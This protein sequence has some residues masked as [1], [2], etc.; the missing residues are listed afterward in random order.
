MKTKKFFSDFFWTIHFMFSPIIVFLFGYCPKKP[1]EIWGMYK[2]ALKNQ[3]FS[4]DIKFDNPRRD[5]LFWYWGKEIKVMPFSI[6]GITVIYFLSSFVGKFV[7]E[8]LTNF[9]EVNHLKANLLLSFFFLFIVHLIFLNNRNKYEY[10]EETKKKKGKKILAFFHFFV[11]WFVVVA[12]NLNLLIWFNNL[13]L[14]HEVSTFFIFDNFMKIVAVSFLFYLVLDKTK[15]I[16]K[17]LL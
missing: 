15:Y 14:H 11:K 12:L 1:K 4:A 9:N 3:D 16:E 10:Y 5:R 6:F 17:Y 2:T 13:F 7:Y 8:L